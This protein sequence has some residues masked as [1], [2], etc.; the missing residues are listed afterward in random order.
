MACANCMASARVTPLRGSPERDPER[1]PERGFACL[2]FSLRGTRARRA[3]EPGRFPC[4][5]LR[6]ASIAGPS[7]LPSVTVLVLI[8]ALA[9]V[10]PERD[11]SVSALV[12]TSAF[13]RHLCSAR[14]GSQA[15]LQAR[16]RQNFE[17]ICGP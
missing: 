2:C 1:D 5:R 12:L 8:C 9:R 14:K 16:P 4:R 15:C 11:P 17:R 10:W 13:V 6:V 7:G 3:G